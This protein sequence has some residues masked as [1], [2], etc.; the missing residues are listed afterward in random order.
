M[1]A[2]EVAEPAP[3]RTGFGFPKSVRL[4]KHSDFDRVYRQGRRY[5]LPNMAMFYL[6]REGDC[7]PQL[8]VGLTVGRALGGAVVRNRIKRRLR[9]AV[10]LNLALPDLRPEFPTDVVINPRKS[11]ATLEFTAL[12]TEVADGFRA[13]RR[14]KGAIRRSQ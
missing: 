8:R 9:E 2:R 1:S 12:Q 11:V 13:I 14:G 5:A 7:S 10:R 4:L 6:R 3:A